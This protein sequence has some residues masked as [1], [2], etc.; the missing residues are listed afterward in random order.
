MT[1]KISIL[2]FYLNILRCREKFLCI[3]SYVTLAIVSIAGIV[4]TFI[5]AFQCR[6][7]QAAYNL[8][9]KNPRCIS[10]ETIYLVSAPVNVGTDLAILVLPIPVLTRINLPWK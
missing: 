1:T 10:F 3:A 2:V 8:A 7:V 9:I 6:P 4:L 5:V